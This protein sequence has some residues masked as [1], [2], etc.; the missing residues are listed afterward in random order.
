MLN[1][2]LNHENTKLK[3]FVCLPKKKKITMNCS[4]AQ[5]HKIIFI[6]HTTTPSCNAVLVI[7]FI[8][9]AFEQ[10]KMFCQCLTMDSG[11]GLILNVTIKLCQ[12]SIKFHSRK[13]FLFI[14]ISHR[15]LD[16]FNLCNAH[17]KISKRERERKQKMGKSNIR[18]FYWDLKKKSGFS[19]F[20]VSLIAM[21]C[22][23]GYELSINIRQHW[24][25]M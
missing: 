12:N 2:R 17:S 20:M 13:L 6:Q 23:N 22:R 4:Y 18:I 16:I 1:H 10:F 5:T 7:C 8:S 19:D 21:L 11:N 14:H 25:A 9:I 24:V 15:C 3:F